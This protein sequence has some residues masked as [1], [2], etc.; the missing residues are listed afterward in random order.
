MVRVAGFVLTV[1]WIGGRI[2]VW[3]MDYRPW[4]IDFLTLLAVPLPAEQA[5]PHFDT[6]QRYFPV[7][8]DLHDIPYQ[9]FQP[10]FYRRCHLAFLLACRL[11]MVYQVSLLALS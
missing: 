4:T 2:K 8:A 10:W 9:I 11:V 7:P 6:F 1:N 3:T 5:A